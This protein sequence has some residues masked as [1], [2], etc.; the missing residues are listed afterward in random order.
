VAAW[1]LF[2]VCHGVGRHRVAP[3]SLDVKIDEAAKGNRIHLWIT[4]IFHMQLL[5]DWGQ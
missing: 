2:G 1:S 3:V 5:S 4:G